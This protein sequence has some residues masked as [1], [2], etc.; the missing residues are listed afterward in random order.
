[1]HSF[2]DE[3]LNKR[4]KK[5]TGYLFITLFLGYYGCITLFSH[6]HHIENGV[7]IVHSHPFRSGT[8]KNPVPHQHTSQGYVLIHYLNSFLKTFLL[9]TFLW[10]I[11]K[12][13]SINPGFS[14]AEISIKLQYLFFTPGLRA[15]P[16]YTHL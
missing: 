16:A 11:I 2:L 15:P 12:R 4:F 8:E 6:V 5:I 14:G 7:I 3:K 9:S 13:C 1:L 10:A